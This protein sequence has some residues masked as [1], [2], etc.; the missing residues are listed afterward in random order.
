MFESN[1]ENA[2][3]RSIM[4]S[5]PS[6]QPPG[7]QKQRDERNG[8]RRKVKINAGTEEGPYLTH[9]VYHLGVILLS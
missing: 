3:S 7:K 8:R 9:R 5:S 6:G 2:E 1:T 4:S